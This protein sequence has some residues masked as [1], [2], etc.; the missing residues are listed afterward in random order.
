M[1]TDGDVVLSPG[2]RNYAATLVPLASGWTVLHYGAYV[3]LGYAPGY[4][5]TT[6][7][8]AP[9]PL[10]HDVNY[11]YP[12][13]GPQSGLWRV[14]DTWSFHYE[15]DGINQFGD[16]KVDTGTDGFDNDLPGQPGYGIVDDPGEMETSPP[17]PVPLRGIQIKIRVFEPD[18]RQIREVTVVQDFLPK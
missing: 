10:F 16:T 13:P 7:P 15:H 8:G 4:D 12:P 6:I 18:S 9:Q 17:Y 2:D 11:D 14:Y 3:D 5:Y 1:I